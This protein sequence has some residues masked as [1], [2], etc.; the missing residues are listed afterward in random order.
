MW[1]LSK[2]VFSSAIVKC[3][4]VELMY[5]GHMSIGH[6]FHYGEIARLVWEQNLFRLVLSARRSRPRPRAS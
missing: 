4:R 6:L 1:N 3:L 2:T 5:G